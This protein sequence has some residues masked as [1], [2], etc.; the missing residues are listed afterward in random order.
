MSRLITIQKVAEKFGRCEETI[1]NW[2]KQGKFPPPITV[3]NK[4]KFWDEGEI[5]KFL[6]KN[7][8]KIVQN[9]SK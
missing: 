4:S 1:R 9:K 8:S 5:E 7:K 2:V 6:L 3:T